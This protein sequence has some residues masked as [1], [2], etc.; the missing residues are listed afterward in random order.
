[1]N[2]L[3]FLRKLIV[4]DEFCYICA[5]MNDC[6]TDP[7][8]VMETKEGMFVW[9]LNE[10]QVDE[11][12]KTE[13]LFSLNSRLFSA[14][15]NCWLLLLNFIDCLVFIDLVLFFFYLGIRL[16]GFHIHYHDH[17]EDSKIWSICI[18][19]WKLFCFYFFLLIFKWRFTKIKM[20]LI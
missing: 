19:D 7:S 3:L 4:C 16:T 5:K 12:L 13:F 17:S 9:I 15:K 6:Y 14:A 18:I 11:M 8:I 1:M 20:F 2:Q 10:L